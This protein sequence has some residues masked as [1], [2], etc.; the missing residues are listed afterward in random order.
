MKKPIYRVHNCEKTGCIYYNISPNTPKKEIKPDDYAVWTYWCRNTHEKH[1]DCLDNGFV[2]FHDRKDIDPANFEECVCGK[3]IFRKDIECSNCGMFYQRTIRCFCEKCG[4]EYISILKNKE[5][6][7]NA[8][9]PCCSPM[10]D[11]EKT[12]WLDRRKNDSSAL[13]Y[14]KALREN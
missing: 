1:I 6:V 14:E 2:N 7:V 11:L 3:I 8:L 12:R 4:S 5:T 13:L 9:C 10:P